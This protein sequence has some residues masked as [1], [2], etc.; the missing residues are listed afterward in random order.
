[1]SPSPG[2]PRRWVCSQLV[3]VPHSVPPGTQSK[4]QTGGQG[5]GFTRSRLRG[6]TPKTTVW[7]FWGGSSPPSSWARVP[8]ACLLGQAPV[9]NSLTLSLLSVCLA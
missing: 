2:N 6:Q 8:W 3:G 9:L 1:M 4:Q 7:G 5:Q